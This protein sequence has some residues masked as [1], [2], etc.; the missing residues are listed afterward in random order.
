MG[1]REKKTKNTSTTKAV[2]LQKMFADN[3]NL[4]F[5]YCERAIYRAKVKKNKALTD[6]WTKIY[7]EVKK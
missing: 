2:Q 7:N 3:I 5:Y 6:H 4:A 1:G